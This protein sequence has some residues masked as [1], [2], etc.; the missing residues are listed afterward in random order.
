[1]PRITIIGKSAPA[2][3]DNPHDSAVLQHVKTGRHFN[4]FVDSQKAGLHADGTF[5]AKGIT[6]AGALTLR[7]ETEHILARCNPHNAVGNIETTHL[8]VGYVQ[9]GKTMSFTGLTALALDNGYRMV[10]Y[11]AGSKNN[12]LNQTAARLKKDLT[13]STENNPQHFK[14]H[15]AP[16][17][18]D[19]N[20]IVGNLYL[21]ETI[22]LVPILKHHKHIDNLIKIFTSSDFVEA[23][24]GETVVIIDDEADQASLNSFGRKNSKKHDDEDYEQSRTYD[25]ILRMRAA[26]PGN[27]YVQ[28]TATP[29]ANILISIK[30]LLSPRSHT[31]LTPGEGYVGGKL[32]FGR[33]K[34]HELFHGRLIQEIPEAEVFHK[35]KNPL[36]DMPKSLL[37]ALAMHI[38]AVAIVVEHLRKPGIRFL[39]MMVHPDN[40]INCNKI[41]K[42]WIENKMKS[43]RKLI[44]KPDGNDD[45]EDMINLFKQLYPKAVEFYKEEERPE[46]EEILP[47]IERVLCSWKVY[48]VN[49]DKEAQTKIDWDNYEMHVLV[50]AE[51]LNR[52]FTVENLST[53]YMPR[54]SCGPTNAD[55][56]QQRC[57]FFG[58]KR[59]YI[60]SCRVFLP[61]KSIENYLEYIDHEEELR[62][63]LS[64]CDNLAEAERKVLLSPRL[65][66][67]RANVLPVSVVSSRLSGFKELQAYESVERIRKNKEMVEEFLRAH[68]SLSWEVV[69][70]NTVDRTHRRLKLPVEE[71]VNFLDDFQFGN[72]RAAMLKAA[73]I[74]YLHFLSE[75]EDAPLTFVYFYQMA[76]K[77]PEDDLRRRTFDSTTHT[78]VPLATGRSIVDK[79]IYPGDREMVGQDSITIQLYHIFLDKAP[80]EF[81]RDAYSIAINYPES[82]ATSYVVNNQNGYDDDEDDD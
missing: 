56:I 72:Y 20:Q 46:F 23:M 26:L 15:L 10:V 53:T 8:A 76:F 55:T 22:L 57:R 67:T 78:V 12:L 21:K 63:I 66:A 2:A 40:T 79:E 31:L 36:K 75:K 68:D 80:V 32:Y 81:A 51:M 34:G 41:F 29:Q 69:E 44:F 13:N 25:A 16:T 5:R 19:L 18:A 35:K 9:S 82:L 52:G 62:S 54:Y 7:K 61:Q 1:M 28:Y 17:T 59:E 33:G 43:W 74:R 48:L 4:A 30:D 14:I 49:T 65:R 60:E 73:T 11:L 38:L 27:S 39:S 71:A 47:L 70:Y 77:R 42:K 45:K 24:K 64:Q 58:Y 50:G 3:N 6:D 37:D